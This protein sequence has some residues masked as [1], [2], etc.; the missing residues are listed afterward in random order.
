M[1]KGML[2]IQEAEVIVN[3]VKERDAAIGRDMSR[4]WMYENHI[5]AAANIAKTIASKIDGMDENQAY[6]CALLHDVCRTNE[7]QEKRFHGIMG[8]EK[9]VSKD[10]MVANSVLVHM[11]PWNEVPS[12]EECR[13]MFFDNKKDYDFIVEYTKNN[14]PNDY[15]LLTQMA[16]S[17]SNKNGIVTLE[18]RAKEYSERH[19][20][21]ILSSMIE[22]RYRLKSYFDKKVGGNIYDL[23]IKDSFYNID[24][25]RE[26]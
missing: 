7:R 21:D 15:D 13:D 6:I 11:F 4:W 22:P 5:R 26:R 8:Y 18:Q 16:D 17:L 3:E 2:L 9:L 20:V 10:E 23:I 1:Q 14:S 19:G 12:Y 24:I 25:S